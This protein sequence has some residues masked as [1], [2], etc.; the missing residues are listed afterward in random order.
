M[1]LVMAKI[2]VLGR[3]L[4]TLRAVLPLLVRG[5]MAAALSWRPMLLTA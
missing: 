2:G 3:N 5:K 4:L 1:S